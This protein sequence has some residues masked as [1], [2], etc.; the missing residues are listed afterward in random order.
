MK[1][2][3]PVISKRS[4]ILVDKMCY[5]HLNMESVFFLISIEHYEWR[6]RGGGLK[7]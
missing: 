2:S 3:E 1:I 4:L 7:G 5:M 6:T